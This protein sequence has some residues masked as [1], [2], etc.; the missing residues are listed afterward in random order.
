MFQIRDS[1]SLTSKGVIQC[2]QVIRFSVLRISFM[3]IPQM[4]LFGILMLSKV[5]ILAWRLLRDR[6]RTK[7]NLV[8]RGII[9]SETALC[10][11]ACGQ[12]ETS[13]HLF[14]HCATFGSLWQLV[15]SWL[16]VTDVDPHSLRDHFIQFTFCLGG[17]KARRSFLQL[18]CV[19][20]IWNERNNRF[21]N[22]IHTS[23]HELMDKVKFHSY[24]WMKANK[25]TF[26]FG[27]QRRWL[28]PLYCLGID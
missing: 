16:G 22:N 23:I 8:H 24:R 18:L 11:M 17:L 1:G 9:V 20:L 21:F 13:S 5:T 15:R 12:T 25:A 2:V 7:F 4:I 28:D 27:C 14:L 6:L 19:W 3:Q 10:T 26:V